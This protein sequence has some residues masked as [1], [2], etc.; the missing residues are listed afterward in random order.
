LAFEVPIDNQIKVWT[1]ATLPANWEALGDRWE[2]YL[3]LRTFMSIAA[4]AAVTAGTLT[5]RP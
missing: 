3:A 1:L 2:F 4:L 5:N